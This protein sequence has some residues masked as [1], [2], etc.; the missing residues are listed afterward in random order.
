[1]TEANDRKDRSKVENVWQAHGLKCKV[2]LT[3]M[4]HRCGY[5]A[6]PKG[7]STY[8]RNYDDIPVDVHGGLTYSSEGT[9]GNY[10]LGF[11]CA[12]SCDWTE[13][14]QT[15]HKWT[16]QDVEA[17]C[18]RLAEQLTRVTIQ[19]IIREKMRWWSDDLRL[20]VQVLDQPMEQK[21]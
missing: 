2:I 8:G 9:D 11:D 1:M 21:A 14:N 3:E 12:H 15:G 5:V 16:Q 4:G 7:H 17:E 19:G 13:F 6:V 18:E 20:Y 10:W